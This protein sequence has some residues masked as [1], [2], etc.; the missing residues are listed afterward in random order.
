MKWNEVTRLDV[1]GG[2]L[3]IKDAMIMLDEDASEPAWPAVNCEPGEYIIE[4]N[5]PNPWICHRLRISKIGSQPSPGNEIG[6]VD[7]DHAF[8]AI[9]DYNS[10]HKAIISDYEEYAEWTMNELDDE[11]AINFSGEIEYNSEKLVYVKS[12]E[13]DGR[14]TVFELIQNEKVIGLE[15]VFIE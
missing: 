13:G 4:I 3:V 5:V 15:C 6:N 12:G 2:V 8:A 11:L 7:I 10:F 9:I 14:Y 1:K